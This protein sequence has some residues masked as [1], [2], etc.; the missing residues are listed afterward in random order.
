MSSTLIAV[1]LALVLGHYVTPLT[2][3]RRYGWFS[4]WVGWLGRQM[5]SAFDSPFASLLALGL[6]LALAGWLQHALE[7]HFYGLSGF[8]F[9]VLVLCY[10]WG[11]RDLDLDV[12]AIEEAND[13]ATR[14]RA[15]RQLGGTRPVVAEEPASLVQAVFHG[16][17]RRWF[18]VLLWFLL[19]GP[20]GALLYRLTERGAEAEAGQALPPAQLAAWQ[21][22]LAILD[23]P[24]A[25]LMTLALAVVGHFDA[26]HGTWREWHVARRGQGFDFSTGF[27][28]DAAQVSVG[29]ALR[30]AA[31]ERE[32][33]DIDDDTG[34]MSP[35]DAP[36]PLQA[37]HAAMTQ[38][39]RILLAWVVVL[40]LFVL[41]GHV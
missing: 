20:F 32:V 4:H 25:H 40:A 16:A 12:E 19:L 38:V 9:A 39:W 6:P 11:P 8:A 7:G 23:W 17:R 34:T 33:D 30:D 31:T 5:G 3:L 18:G 10:C 21:H 28:D 2:R 13:D 37:L 26:V 35:V 36:L 22:L 29:Q 24:V 41:A 1:V 14:K 15:L 27:L